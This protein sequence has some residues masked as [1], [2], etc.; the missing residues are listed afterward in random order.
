MHQL[1]LVHDDVWAALRGLVSACGGSKV[2]GPMLWPSKPN[3]AQWLDECLNPDRPAKLCLEEFFLLLR[4]GRAK[5]WHHAKHFV[6]DE[7]LYERTAP[8]DSEGEVTQ[9]LRER[10]RLLEAQNSNEARLTT[11]L[12][13]YADMPL[14]NVSSLRR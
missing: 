2:V 9:L 13:R 5:G 14:G 6:D 4:I 1:D 11:L 8:K 3:S 12:E 10:N 7:T